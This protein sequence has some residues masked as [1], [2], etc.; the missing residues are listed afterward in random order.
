MDWCC[1]AAVNKPEVLAANLAASPS[2]SRHP[3]LLNI[4]ENCSSASIAYNRGLQETTAEI[5]VFAHQDVYLPEGWD[6]L[7]EQ[8]V[9]ELDILDPTWAVAGLVGLTIENRVAG[10]VWSTG[11]VREIGDPSGLP[12]ATTCIDELLI[13]LKRS[14]GVRFDPTLPNFHLYGMDIVQTARASGRGAYIVHAPVVHNSRP[15]QTLEGGY[16]EAYRYMQDKLADSLPL[17]TLI[18]DL[19]AD[20][21]ELEN[22]K[23]RPVFQ[24]WR[25]RLSRRW[26]LF[27]MDWRW[28]LKSPSPQAI[29]YRVGYEE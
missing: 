14:S 25:R 8:R 13:V 23:R 21:S 20:D 24:V 18:I 12:V 22:E 3:G 1:V 17:P 11:L 10:H 26:R 29:S 16:T 2:L 9:R 7:L 28:F 27:R 15:V 4:Q 5:V 19:C 6:M